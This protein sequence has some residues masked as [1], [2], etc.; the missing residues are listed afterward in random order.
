[1]NGVGFESIGDIACAIG[2]GE[3]MRL[4]MRLRMSSGEV[5]S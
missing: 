2:R 4:G 1:M 5:V 3:M